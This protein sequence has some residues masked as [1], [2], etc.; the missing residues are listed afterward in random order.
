[1][2]QLD[3]GRDQR[4]LPIQDSS[5]P[6][7]A[8][9][10]TTEGLAHALQALRAGVPMRQMPPQMLLALSHQVGNSA[11]LDILD[12]Q[13]VRIEAPASCFPDGELMGAPAPAQP[14]ALTEGAPPDWAAMPACTLEAASPITAEGG[15]AVART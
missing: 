14:P 8:Q 9:R 4:S 6:E 13:S 1:M 7:T 3:Q 11:L 5:A 12:G 15:E 10:E 2:E